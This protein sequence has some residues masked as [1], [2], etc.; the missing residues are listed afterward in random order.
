MMI[1]RRVTIITRMMTVVVV[2]TVD[3]LLT[4]ELIPEL[5]RMS[6]AIMHDDN[7]DL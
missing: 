6:A 4:T 5:L 1:I 3:F 2:V 7:E